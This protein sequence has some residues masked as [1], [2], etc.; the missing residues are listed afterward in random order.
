MTPERQSQ[1]LIALLLVPIG[2]SFLLPAFPGA[3]VGGAALLGALCVLVLGR[4]LRV[5]FVVAFVGVVLLVATV[6]AFKS[7]GGI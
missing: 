3:L 4:A 2:S 7:A 5:G 6:T 1:V